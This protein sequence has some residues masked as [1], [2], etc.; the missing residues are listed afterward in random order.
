MRWSIINTIF[1]KELKEILRDKRMVY[2]VI[3]LPFFLYPVMFAL[4]GTISSS[5]TEK[6]NQEKVNVLINEAVV[7]SAI[8]EALQN[9]TTL[10]IKQA[11]F[12]KEGLDTMQNTI[13]LKV[14]ND[15]NAAML[16]N[17]PVQTEIYYNSTKDVL[18][19]RVSRIKR[20]IEAIN[21]SVVAQ[22]L[23]E[24]ELDNS[25]L[26]PIQLNEIDIAPPAA[27]MGKLI[28]RFLPM[29]LI[30]FIFFGMLTVSIDLTAGEKERRT[31]QTL[32]VSPIKVR[33]IITG[34]FLAVFTV[35]VVSAIM[36]LLSLLLA[37]FIQAK[38]MG[39]GDGFSA[40]SFSVSSEGWTW[41]IILILLTT[42]FI[43]GM[44]LA[45]VVLANTYKEAQSYTSPLMLIF[46]LPAVFASQPGMELTLT[47]ALL[48][49]IN[50]FLA[51]GEIFIGNFNSGLV[52]LVALMALVYA[53]LALMLASFIFGNENVVTGQK[54][55][56]KKLFSK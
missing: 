15:A 39:A 37:V 45:V 20:Q 3:L 44:T 51:M 21:Q 26:T 18:S 50:I 34:K 8:Y 2:L 32:F 36:N 23:A 48:P 43:G 53:I 35:G 28:G 55:D 41:L 47:T 54:I 29:F 25:F 49:V 1:N 22:R 7:S 30:F 12:T 11:T 17:Q 19:N 10:I 38:L 9:D 4:I 5:Q 56:F 40:I 27:Q 24:R 31:L 52:A 33:E 16:E 46:L 6:I 14:T 42:I 13:G